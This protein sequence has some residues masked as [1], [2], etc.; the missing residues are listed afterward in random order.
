MFFSVCMPHV[1]EGDIDLAADLT[2]GV[3]G[4]ADAAGLGNSLE[5]GGDVDAVAEDIVVIKDD[6]ADVNADAKLDPLLR[7]DIGC[8]CPAIARWISTAQRDPS[9]TLAN[10]ASNP[11]P[12]VLT[13]RP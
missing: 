10:S 1:V 4:K 2:L 7:R 3:V 6:I 11:S 12:V 13:I 8:S 5:P 9:T